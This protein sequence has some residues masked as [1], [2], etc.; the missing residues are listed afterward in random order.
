[1]SAVRTVLHSRTSVSEEGCRW[2]DTVH[3]LNKFFS[4]LRCTS[5]VRLIQ[6]LVPDDKIEAVM[7]VLNGEGIDYVRQRVWSRGD[8]RWLVEFPVPT[9]AIRHV[10]NE[11]EVA[12]VDTN[13]Y[14]TVGSLESAITPNSETLQERFADDFDPLTGH[15][16]RSKARD[17]SRDTRSFIV[18]IFLS[19]II[20]VAGLLI[21]SPAV[22][23]G[24]MVI[25]PIV[26]PVMTAAVGAVTADREMLVRSVWIQAAGLAVAIVGATAFSFGLKSAGFFPSHLD[27]TSIDLIALRV[28]PSFVAAV[29]GLAAG[30]AGAFGL[31]TKGP[32]SLIGVMIAAALIPAAATVGIA[33]TWGEYRI[34]V[35]SLLL[36]ALTMILINLGAFAA[37]RRF[38]GPEREGWLFSSESSHRRIEVVATAL[39]VVALVAAVGVAS[40]QQIAFERTVTEE[41]ESILEGSGYEDIELVTVR[42]QYQGGSFGDPETVTVILSRTAD[43]SDPPRLAGAFRER[44]IG[45]TGEE[46]AVKVQFQEYQRPDG[47]DGSQP[48]VVPGSH[49]DP[50]E[51][52]DERYRRQVFPVAPRGVAE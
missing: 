25:A 22:I 18:M 24:S 1:M 7:D 32:T 28:A 40:Y 43:G 29:I 2:A 47:N 38:Y 8:E 45:A 44:I 11:L 42:T 46:V 9:D 12:G 36:L 23:V 19:A 39:T 6:V 49:F 20:A 51:P 21:E 30:A 16:L 5:S 50:R 27:I 52:D 14:L 34:A 35:G 37:L 31:M 4:R 33:I 13:Q 17:Q 48:V 10:Q 15:E 41:I 3:S 26:G